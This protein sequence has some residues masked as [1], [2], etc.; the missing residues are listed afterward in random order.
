[1]SQEPIIM[2]LIDRRKLANL[3][4]EKLASSAGMSLKT[5]QRIERGEADIKNVSVSFAHEDVE[6][7]RFGCGTGCCWRITSD[8]GRRSGGQ[9]FTDQRRENVVDQTDFVGQK[10]AVEFC[11]NRYRLFSK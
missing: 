5:Y 9:S 8:S 10:A 3:S 11:S 2:A 6:S 4:Q 7:Y 1:M